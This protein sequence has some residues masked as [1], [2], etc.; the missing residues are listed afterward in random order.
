MHVLPMA[1]Q[2]AIS[3][4]PART[5]SYIETWH[6]VHLCEEASVQ[7]STSYSLNLTTI[8]APLSTYLVHILQLPL[9]RC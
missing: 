5:S 2:I 7:L 4:P 6:L 9:A 1:V 8:S 3:L